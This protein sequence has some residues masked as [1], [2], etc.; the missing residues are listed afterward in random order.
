M[1]KRTKT[2][3]EGF[4][5]LVQGGFPQG[6]TVLLIGTPGTGKTLFALEY[7]VNGAGKY[8]EKSMFVSFEQNLTEVREQAKGVGLDLISLEKKGTLTLLAYPIHKL[9]AESVDEI[10]QIVKKK[11]IKRLVIDSLST[12]AVNAP[13]HLPIQDV[14][15]KDVM[16]DKVFFSPPILGDFMIRR[17]ISSFLFDLKETGCTTIVTA[18]APE[19]GE[20]MTRDTV[21]EFTCDGILLLTF[22]SMGG[23]YSRSLLVRKMRGTKN[24]EDVHPLEISK[25][26]IV[27]HT[28]K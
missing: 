19:K 6:F 20:F 27:I 23:E 4:D 2:G 3:I 17:F 14:A 8:K 10:K 26:G 22:E 18:E 21:S 25:E 9:T 5:K 28:I 12:L 24:D 15:L 16:D 1:I 7:L 13:I 11:K